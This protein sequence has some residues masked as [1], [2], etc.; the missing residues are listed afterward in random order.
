MRSRSRRLGLETYPWSRRVSS[1]IFSAMS[2]SR[3]PGSRV[4][5]RSRGLPS[6]SLNFT[7]RSRRVNCKKDSQIS[8]LNDSQMLRLF[9]YS[10]HSCSYFLL[11]GPRV[12][13]IHYPIIIGI[14]THCHFTFVNS[15]S[16][17]YCIYTQNL[18]EFNLISLPTCICRYCVA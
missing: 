17:Y 15:V 5:S 11:R 4:S 1:R 6:R 10:P 16:A 18:C 3:E 8:D 2:R 12:T 14:D 9:M 13:G 7:S